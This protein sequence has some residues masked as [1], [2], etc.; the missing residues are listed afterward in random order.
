ML[1]YK[2]TFPNTK[3]YIGQTIETL[4]TRIS[5]HKTDAKLNR[6]ITDYNPAGSKICNAIRKY[7]LEIEWVEIIDKASTVEELNDKE[8]YWID[9]FQTQNDELGYNIKPGGG[10]RQ[11]SEETKVKIGLATKDRWQNPEIAN[12]MMDGLKL[13]TET[14][15][16]KTT[17]ERERIERFEV[18]CPICHKIFRTTE[19]ENQQF[20]S[21]E[22]AAKN[23]SNIAANKKIENQKN[24]NTQRKE[25]VLEWAKENYS[26]V[27]NC[28]LN[29]ISTNLSPLLKL[30]GIGDWRTLT[31][32]VANVES[33][34]DFL[35]FLKDYL[36]IYADPTGE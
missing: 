16:N 32:S 23:A 19:K 31:K 7:G 6:D 3:K 10:N 15:K 4:S 8:E 22:C 17:E 26:L 20:C 18:E 29:Q 35:L 24:I 12:K 33:R 13:A 1:I 34:K 21:K 36:K 27:M 5:H 2:I 14:W 28:P 9:Y 30:V 25:L 11:H